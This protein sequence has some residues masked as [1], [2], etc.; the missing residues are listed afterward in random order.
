MHHTTIKNSRPSYEQSR[1]ILQSASAQRCTTCQKVNVMWRERGCRPYNCTRASDRARQKPK[2]LAKREKKEEK[3]YRGY[4]SCYQERAYSKGITE[5]NDLKKCKTV[6]KQSRAKFLSLMLLVTSNR[7]WE[8][9][10]D[11]KH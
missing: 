6:S 11:S 8:I 4:T 9:A 1:P 3:N 2:P 7:A 5:K 10:C